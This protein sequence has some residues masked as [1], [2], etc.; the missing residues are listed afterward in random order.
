MMIELKERMERTLET[1]V[2]KVEY[3]LHHVVYWLAAAG[4]LL[5]MELQ[6]QETLRKAAVD[7][8]L[9]VDFFVVEAHQI[10]LLHRVRDHCGRTGGRAVLIQ[11]EHLS[12]RSVG[13]WQTFDDPATYEVFVRTRGRVP[14]A[15]A[16]LELSRAGIPY[17]AA[18]KPRSTSG[19][20]VHA[21]LAAEAESLITYYSP[22]PPCPPWDCFTPAADD[23]ITALADELRADLSEE[24]LFRFLAGYF[25]LLKE[26]DN[27]EAGMAD[28]DVREAVGALADEAA[29]RIWRDKDD[30]ESMG[31]DYWWRAQRPGRSGGLD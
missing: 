16:R 1:R 26:E 7:S 15:E 25:S 6:V 24:G 8:P 19:V 2:R 4:E 17:R 18:G 22:L 20:Y 10:G 21:D 29:R 23:K 5:E 30:A 11:G 3:M 31:E 9:G 28:T 12:F 14:L 27:L 13:P